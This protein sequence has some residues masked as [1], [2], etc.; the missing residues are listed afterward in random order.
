MKTHV[1]RRPAHVAAHAHP[2]GAGLHELSSM[3]RKRTFERTAAPCKE[4]VRI[5]LLRLSS[6]S[7]SKNREGE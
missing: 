4:P 6:E 7:D 2:N 3:P 5:R 1:G